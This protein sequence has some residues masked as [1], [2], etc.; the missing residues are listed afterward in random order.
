MVHPSCTMCTRWLI[1]CILTAKLLRARYPLKTRR[2]LSDPKLPRRILQ[3][4]IVICPLLPFIIV[5]SE[6]AESPADPLNK[7]VA[8]YSYPGIY[9]GDKQ[10]T[11]YHNW[12]GWL[13]TSC[14]GTTLDKYDD[15]DRDR[16]ETA[17][18]CGDF[19][20]GGGSFRGG[21]NDDGFRGVAV[22]GYLP[23]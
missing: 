19:S 1:A 21:D 8:S 11:A 7:Y 6:C 2:H 5:L 12:V 14:A 18:T 4:R 20:V 10:A 9:A 17:G 16:K 15:H 13:S 3:H 22:V 23:A